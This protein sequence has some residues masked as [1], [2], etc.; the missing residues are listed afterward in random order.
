MDGTLVSNIQH[1]SEYPKDWQL[2][3]QEISVLYNKYKEAIS[4]MNGDT[5]KVE[6]TARQLI[7]LLR[8]YMENRA[9]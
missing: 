1:S 9:A 3:E 7:L 2:Q 6:I 5:E 4:T 8:L